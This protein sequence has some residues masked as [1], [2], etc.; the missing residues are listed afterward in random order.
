MKNIT[1]EE[2]IKL[3]AM[4]PHP[5]GGFYRETY[6]SRAAANGRNVCTAI[7][8]LLPAGAKSR[9]HRLGSD[10]LWHF[11]LGGPITIAQ[12]F[13]DGREERVTLGPDPRAGQVQQ[14]A[15]PAGC[16]FGAYPAPGTKYALVGCTVAPGFDFDDFEIGGS[17]ALLKDFPAS[18]ELIKKLA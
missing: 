2:L 17:A 9:L 3:Y 15:V 14:H 16:W 12:I 4:K 1:I 10:E 18:A 5:E 8:F 6:R 7:Y 11:Y 13:P